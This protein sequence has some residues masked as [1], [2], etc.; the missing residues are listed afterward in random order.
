MTIIIIKK[1]Y[2]IHWY[3]FSII[4][5]PY[6][7]LSHLK[8]N[9]SHFFK[10]LYFRIK[11]ETNTLSEIN[12]MTIIIIK[13]TICD[14]L[15]Q[16]LQCCVTINYLLFKSNLTPPFFFKCL[17]QAMKVSCMYFCVRGI[18]FASFYTYCFFYYYYG[19]VIITINTDVNILSVF[20]DAAIPV[21]NINESFFK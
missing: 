15:I 21:E 7:L 2:V 12:N 18:N 6:I 17:Y 20:K 10:I 13:K 14:T 16:V 1:Q 4:I 11:L 8:Q 19:H 3:R 5:F 9:K